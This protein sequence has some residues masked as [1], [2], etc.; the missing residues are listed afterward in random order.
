MFAR[1]GLGPDLLALAHVIRVTDGEARR[2]FGMT[3][4]G[5]LSGLA[6]PYFALDSNGVRRL[7]ARIR[8]DHPEMKDGKPDNKYIS[9]S[10]ITYK[11]LYFVPG[12]DALLN[13]PSTTIVLVEAEKST[14]ALWA[15]NQR[16]AA[17][18]LPIGLGGCYGWTGKRGR[19]E[20]GPSIDLDCCNGRNVVILLDS[21]AAIKQQVRI[22]RARLAQE[23]VNRGSSVKIAELPEAPG[24]NGPDDGLALSGDQIIVDVLGNA[25]DFAEVA[26][27]QLE[28]HIFSAAERAGRVTSEEIEQCEELLAAIP[29]EAERELLTTRLHK[30]LKG[31]ISKGTINEAVARLRGEHAE[32]KKRIAEQARQGELR[33]TAVDTAALVADLERYF[34]ER[35]YLPEG[36][37]LA[38]SYWTMNTWVFDVF[39]TVPYLNLESAVPG[40][41]KTTVISLLRICREA[42]SATAMT[43]ATLYRIVASA[44]PTLL[45]DE[46]EFL[47][48]KGDRAE[49]IRA[50]SN[51]GYKKGARVPRC[52]GKEQEFELDWFDVYGPKLFSI[53]GGLSGTLLERSIVCHMEKRPAAVQLKKTRERVL[54]RDAKPIRRQLEAYALQKR[55]DLETLYD[56]E[57]D[58]GYWP[59]ITDREAE[60]WGPLL[61]H[62]RLA[63]PEAEKKL[64]A[65][66]DTLTRQKL[67]IQDEDYNRALAGELREA[68]QETTGE[69][70]TPADLLGNLNGAENWGAKLNKYKVDD[71]KS[72]ASAVGRFL[73]KFRFQSKERAR[74]G[75]S[76]KATSYL[77]SEALSVL[78][79]LYPQNSAAS[80]ALP[81]DAG[82]PVK[83]QPV[84]QDAEKTPSAAR[85]AANASHGEISA[86]FGSAADAADAADFLGVQGNTAPTE[87]EIAAAL[88]REFQSGS[89]QWS[90]GPDNG[91][92]TVS[93]EAQTALALIEQARAEGGTVW[94]ESKN[95]RAVVL[96]HSAKKPI[97]ARLLALS[98]D[99]L[100]EASAEDQR[101][102]TRIQTWL[103]EEAVPGS[104]FCGSVRAFYGAYARYCDN[105]AGASESED[106]FRRMLASRIQ[107][108]FM[109][110]VCLA[111][112]CAAA[113]TYERERI[114]EECGR[115]DTGD[116]IENP[117]RLLCDV[118]GIHEDWWI[119][120]VPEGAEMLCGRCRPDPNTTK[121]LVRP[122]SVKQ[123][124]MAPNE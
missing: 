81:H 118:H 93:P 76:S 88:K 82:N 69:R 112:D 49:M 116:L 120:I 5:D 2:L 28:G 24:L 10:G 113:L 85:S 62:A 47:E 79:S 104:G 89:Q 91:V 63:G 122:E 35:A 40:C 121:T 57:P 77:R 15:W 105:Q 92:R 4:S 103:I 44:K 94:I 21:N 13:D 86:L 96:H 19:D 110:G 27:I 26:R 58:E 48:G 8:R 71:S 73:T 78:S 3:F 43:E 56:K 99:A 100:I 33:R 97:M 98:R 37:A 53:I 84:T 55:V 31:A 75:Q 9:E 66:C 64:L 25:R 114:P 51:V 12:S 80:A 54:E 101:R 20:K 52:K 18:I 87:D 72:R 90:G 70:F 29:D 50:I 106:F 95:E 65:A 107:G 123:S 42:I 109:S 45:I 60:V 108:A 61:V 67:S 17:G 83:S 102:V 38:L 1:Y 16:Q 11:R 59:H 115:G 41:G 22:A 68:I 46:A 6:F 117:L 36:A 30:V 23:L 32:E 14:L 34:S 74:T 39:D 124:R 7:M 119:N 111:E